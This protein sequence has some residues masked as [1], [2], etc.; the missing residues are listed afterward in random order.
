ML[1]YESARLPHERPVPLNG[2][3]Y[4]NLFFN[5][6]PIDWPHKEMRLTE[7]GQLGFSS[8]EAHDKYWQWFHARAWQH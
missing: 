4:A 2:S 3:E 5:Y 6:R 7:D 1:L 8:K